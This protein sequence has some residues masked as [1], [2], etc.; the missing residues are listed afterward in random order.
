MSISSYRKILS[1]IIPLSNS[2]DEIDDLLEVFLDSSIEQRKKFEV[3]M[4]D[5]GS[6]DDTFKYVTK[7]YA[8]FSDLIKIY[9]QKIKGEGG[10]LNTALHHAG[11]KYVKILQPE[12]RLDKEKFSKILTF[13]EAN[14]YDLVIHGWEMIDTDLKETTKPFE[15][16]DFAT[17]PRGEIE[18]IPPKLKLDY[19]NMIYLKE[20]FVKNNFQAVED[21]YFSDIYTTVW[22]MR[23]A[24]TFYDISDVVLYRKTINHDTQKNSLEKYIKYEEDFWKVLSVILTEIDPLNKASKDA[25]TYEV[26]RLMLFDLTLVWGKNAS[27]WKKHFTTIMTLLEKNVYLFENYPKSQFAKITKKGNSKSFKT[28]ASKSLKHLDKARML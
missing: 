13:I 18:E 3:I 17:V 28:Y 21:F 26:Y 24:K 6:I 1:I 14:S 5:D 16:K 27:P 10:V 19:K 7:F 22:F 9:K 15:S 23:Y 25:I 4:V 11:G 12:D 2:K 20:V 8:K